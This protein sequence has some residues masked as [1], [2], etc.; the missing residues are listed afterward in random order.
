MGI[1]GM[2]SFS[3]SEAWCTIAI[4]EVVLLLVVV[5]ATDCVVLVRTEVRAD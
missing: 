3:D 5:A 4:V 2:A 1:T